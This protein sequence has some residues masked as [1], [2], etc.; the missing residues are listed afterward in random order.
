MGEI[1]IEAEYRQNPQLQKLARALL[2]IARR[3]VAAGAVKDASVTNPPVAKPQPDK[4]A[5]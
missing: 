1:K 2:S 4:D 3:Q 5:A